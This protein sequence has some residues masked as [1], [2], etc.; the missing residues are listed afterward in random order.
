MN[1][2]KKFIFQMRC[3]LLSH[4]TDAE[5]AAANNCARLGYKVVYQQPIIT[6]RK[7]YFADIYLPELKTIL[8]CDGGYHYTTKQKR[9]DVNRSAGIWRLDYHVVRLNNH[10]A[11]DIRK[12]K[13]KLDMI[14][15]K[16][17]GR[18]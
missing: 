7:I 1:I 12:V 6:G 11:R 3:E 14:L 4:L 5:K 16:A 8:E 18:K 2:S 9:K 15:K 17:G 10:D 13:A